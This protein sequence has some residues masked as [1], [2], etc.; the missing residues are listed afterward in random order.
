MALPDRRCRNV[1]RWPPPPRR[2]TTSTAAAACTSSIDAEDLP[3]R[4]RRRTRRGCP[5]ATSSRSSTRRTCWAL[6]TAE[7]RDPLAENVRP[8]GRYDVD[9]RVGEQ[10]CP[11]GDVD[12][13]TG[14]KRADRT[15]CGPGG[16]PEPCIV[17][18]KG[19]GYMRRKADRATERH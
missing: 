1:W 9:I 2:Y 5:A 11:H 4:R 14:P 16:W 8:L 12:E 6:E 19:T 3:A 10:C 17:P 13:T 7:R 15:G 18:G